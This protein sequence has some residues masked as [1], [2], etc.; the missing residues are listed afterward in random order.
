M[1]LRSG[2]DFI[3]TPSP[4]DASFA[5]QLDASATALDG[6]LKDFKLFS[7][8]PLELQDKIFELS[9]PQLQGRLIEVTTSRLN[10]PMPECKGM[11]CLKWHEHGRFD[12]ANKSPN[13]FAT[14]QVCQ[15]SRARALRMLPDSLPTNTEGAVI[16]FNAQHDTIYITNSAD[17]RFNCQ[18]PTAANYGCH[19]MLW[20][21][22]PLCL[23]NVQHIAVPKFFLGTNHVG[24]FE[25]AVTRGDC[26]FWTSAIKNGFKNLKT[27][28]VVELEP[29]F[30]YQPDFSR[31]SL[32]YLAH[33][34]I[35]RKELR[36]SMDN[37]PVIKFVNSAFQEFPRSR[38]Y[39]L[40]QATEVPRYGDRMEWVEDDVPPLSADQVDRHMADFNRES[41]EWL[42]K[43]RLRCRD[44]RVKRAIEAA[45]LA[46]Q[47][48]QQSG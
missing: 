29:N 46:R 2:N 18:N 25:E 47:S 17:H 15:R 14:M 6:T 16:R 31:P 5:D 21:P 28:T 30:W 45:R 23:Q 24:T 39:L 36:Q 38:E 1:Q 26:G 12:L 19:E 3:M 22:L 11:T 35:L 48:S 8:L 34:G 40:F 7:K 20:S 32:M 41:A 33:V 13:Q 44:E 4:V 42:E 9:T 37:P 43:A 27:I 10:C